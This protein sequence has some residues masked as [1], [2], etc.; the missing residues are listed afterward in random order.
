[1]E[2]FIYYIVFFG[3][4]CSALCDEEITRSHFPDG[5]LF[6][7]AT[8][9]YQIEGAVLEDGRGPSNWDVFTHIPG[10]IADGLNA[11]VADDHY[12]LWKDD[13]ELM[14]SLGVNAYRFS[15]SWS[16]ILPR[17]RF[18]EI[19]HSG[20]LF[21]NKLIDSL[22]LHGIEPFV[23]LSHNDVPHELEK[24]Y[25]SWLSPLIQDDFAYFADICFRSFGNRVKYW[26]TINEPVLFTKF[27]YVNGTYP[28]H[29]C[30]PPFG[31]CSAGNSDIEPLVVIHNMILSHTKAT[32]IYRKHY[33]PEQGGYIGIV[34]DAMWYESYK[35]DVQTRA[36]VN[37]AF[38]FDIAWILDPLIHGD[39]PIE[40]RQYFGGDL[41]TFSAE[42]S[43]KL[44]DGLDFIGIN[45]YTSCYIKDCI[46][47]S[48]DP[49]NRRPISGYLHRTQ[50]RDGVLIGEQTAMPL[51]SVV[52]YGMEKIID[53][54]KTR[55]NNKP[56]FV[57]ENGYPGNDPLES[58]NDLVHDMKRVEYHKSY[59]ASLAR[60]IER[61]ADVRGYF[62][63]SL[64]D[65]FEW[66]SGY[67]MKLGL[68]YVDFHTL[69]RMPKLSAKWY[70]KFLRNGTARIN[71]DIK[72]NPT[73][74][75][76]MF[77]SGYVEKNS[78]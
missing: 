68:H 52:P 4:L 28:P 8:S 33:Q 12:H 36:A 7:T 76:W 22:L 27:A 15:I 44:K 32:Q 2:G 21:Y 51:F 13:V 16:R 3:L 29:R 67:T 75:N 20:I 60:A 17:G 39:Y 62:I 24:R 42:E 11:D 71:E 37:R 66:A 9:S 1:M 57:T 53:F 72:E 46:Y 43:N 40:M 47:S 49:V 35:D 58:V 55:Y 34:V 25:K 14:H 31:N 56:M 6:G 10:N 59:L 65:N 50:E 30:S 5:F 78:L 23:T 63:W 70:K 45:H 69:K 77:Q 61:G 41:P 19:N 64:M 74:K 38:A 54:L 73:R 26:A 18:G 48:C